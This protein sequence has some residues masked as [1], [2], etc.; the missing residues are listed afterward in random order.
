MIKEASAA[1]FRRARGVQTALVALL[2]FLLGV[3][4]AGLFLHL[5]N[6]RRLELEHATRDVYSLTRI[7]AE[8]VRSTIGAVD[9]MLLLLKNLQELREIQFNPAF[10]LKDNVLLKDADLR[11][12]IIGADG[13]AVYASDQ[14]GYAGDRAYFTTHAAIDD[15]KLFI[16]PPR[17]AP[18]D[19]VPLIN[20]SRRLNHPD[21]SFAGVVVIAFDPRVLMGKTSSLGVAVPTFMGVIGVD[22]IIRAISAELPAAFGKVGEPLNAPVLFERVAQSPER[23]EIDRSV[24][25]GVERVVAW[26][27]LGDYPL[28][29][30]AARNVDAVLADFDRH[31]T[32]L[33]GAAAAISC[34]LILAGWLLIE[35]L[36]QRARLAASVAD[37]RAHLLEAQQLGKIGHF[38]IDEVTGHA[39][40]SDECFAL[41][42][43][44][45]VPRDPAGAALLT[46][47]PDD[48]PAYLALRDGSGGEIELRIVR[49]DGT[50]R[51][52]HMRVTPRLDAAGK[53]TGVFG[54]SQDITARKAAEETAREQER[55][56]R[57]IMD[58]APVSIFLKDRDGR[59]L[60]VNKNFTEAMGFPPEMMIGR[61][62]EELSPEIAALSRAGD[63]AVLQRGEITRLERRARR[64]T[65]N[66]EYIELM[67]FPIFDEDGAITG[68]AGFTFNI[69]E[70]RRIEAQLREAAKLEAVGRL[71]GGLAHDV[72]NMI[73][74]IAGFA[75]FL[76]EDLDPKSE[77]YRFVTRIEQVCR[78]AKD[79]VVQVLA[80]ARAG[81][82]EKH[83]IDLVAAA[84]ED[85]ALLRGALPATTALSIEAGKQRLPVVINRGQVHQLLLNLCVNASD[86]LEGQ[87]GEVAVRLEPIE[88]GHPDHRRFAD[89]ADEPEVA[90]ARGG[91]LDPARRYVALRVTDTGCGMDQATLD[92]AF[93]PFYSTKAPSRGTGLGLAVIHG[94]VAACNGAYLVTSRL[95]R[96]SS[97]TLY[98]PL[99]D[100]PAI[101]APAD[102]ADLPAISL[103][104]IDDESAVTDMLSTGLERL[105]YDVTCSNDPVEALDAFEAD[106]AAWDV[107]ITDHVMPGL[108]G[109]TVIERIK[110][111]RPD[112]LA[113]LLTGF[114]D[115]FDAHDAARKAGAD[116][117]LL[118]PVD[119]RHLDDQMRALLKRK[120]AVPV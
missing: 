69:T 45:P 92:R 11:V 117:C 83:T 63:E 74:A 59:Y 5:S 28:L 42:G 13:Y 40:F 67:K 82:V 9:Q 1:D 26:Q 99:T 2:V 94:I 27:V 33:V 4:W 84:A 104:V 41:M 79:L 24:T 15:G 107:V 7:Y 120:A 85:S 30:A 38:L 35:T 81:R 95:G 70:R 54:V 118:K 114:A 32:I 112:C 47:H 44:P 21:G 71:A 108:A 16:G 90:C 18:T 29:V 106:P 68:L 105:G 64:T 49:P 22:R 36:N 113:I 86:A 111:R 34:V 116:A 101:A 103:L 100:D 10:T 102:A 53:R 23:A 55:R 60:L 3:L 31:Q 96:G 97:F 58:N 39:T 52:A 80:F 73:G 12:R 6:Q 43:R 72:N 8:Q 19:A 77:Q 110:R 48:L 51:W 14:P 62:D 25:D 46:I 57:A 20:L 17:R 37:S 75:S 65:P 98:L 76:L 56:L 66:R 50:M 87:P 115:R 109:T 91:T 93:E 119:P 88:P 61:T 89:D 78:Q